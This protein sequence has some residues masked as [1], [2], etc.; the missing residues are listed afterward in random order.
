MQTYRKDIDGLRAIAVLSVIAFHAH[1]SLFRGGFIGVDVFFVIS[2]YLMGS[3][4]I[5]DVSMGKFS[6]VSFYERRIR[7]IFPAL[8]FMILVTSLLAYYCLLPSELMDYGRSVIAATFSFS[9]IYF[10]HTL[11]YFH[12]AAPTIPLLHTWSLA[13]EEQFYVFLPIFIIIAY[14]IWPTKLWLF[15]VAATLVSFGLSTYGT[16]ADRTSAYYL[17]QSRAWELLLGTLVSLNSFPHVKAAIWRNA[18][19]LTG[20]ALVIV[21]VFCF[22]P[23]TIF[24]GFAALMPC[25]GAALII[26][27]GRWGASQAGHMLSWRPLVFVGQISYSLYLWH[28]P[29]IVFMR[30][31]ELF[32]LGRRVPHMTALAVFATTIVATLSWKYVEAPFRSGPARP[33]R[34]RLFEIAGA[35]AVVLAAIGL[36]AIAS[37][38]VPARYSTQ[39]NTMLLT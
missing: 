29:L 23:S 24:P 17:L 1:P 20:V 26:V 4:I 7:R 36:S 32:P 15:L 13:V 14:R 31:S 37:R 5:K 3:L 16:F 21:S 11:N 28:W 25:T 27:A 19:S 12:R 2:G 10:D 8:A 35:A 18:A 30:M 6:I 33:S 39:A 38:G 9:N 34:M 22:S